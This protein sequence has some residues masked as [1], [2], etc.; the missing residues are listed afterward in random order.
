M[1]LPSD[2]PAAKIARP[3]REA[4][5]KTLVVEAAAGTARPPSWSRV[6]SA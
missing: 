3:I 1:S 6:S 5:D 4:L 2:A